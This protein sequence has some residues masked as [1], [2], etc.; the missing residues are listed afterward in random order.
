MR[1]PKKLTVIQE[2]SLLSVADMDS[3][4]ILDRA[5]IRTAEHDLNEVTLSQATADALLLAGMV[6]YVSYRRVKITEK[7]LDTV[8]SLTGTQR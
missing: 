1:A 8:R 7:G 2:R 5:C 3:V 4:R 6:R